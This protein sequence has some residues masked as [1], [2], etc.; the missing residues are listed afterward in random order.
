MTTNTLCPCG[1]DTPY[2]QCCE[3]IIQGNT[4]AKTPEALMR[5]RYSAFTQGEIEFVEKTNYGKAKKAFDIEAARQWSREAIWHGLHVLATS[6]IDENTTVAYV[7][8]VADCEEQ[9]QR[10]HAHERSRFEKIDGQWF[11][12]DGLS[13]NQAQENQQDHTDHT[14]HTDHQHHH[15]HDG[16]CCDHDHHPKLKPA[17]STKVGRNEPCPCGSGKKYKKCCA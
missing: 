11:Y 5:A 1:S 9:G 12:T 2:T 4:L 6:K 15:H 16:A 14:D 13:L 10:Y 3:S 17:K 8:F 7:E